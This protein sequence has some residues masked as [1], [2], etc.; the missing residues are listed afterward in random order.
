MFDQ[1]NYQIYLYYINK[2]INYEK[3]NYSFFLLNFKNIQRNFFYFI[4][5]FF[6]FEVC[7]ILYFIYK[8]FFS[9]FY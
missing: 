6:I 8:P 3:V 4:L 7:F 9:E 1:M 5:I 2:I